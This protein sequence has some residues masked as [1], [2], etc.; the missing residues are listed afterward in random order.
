MGGTSVLSQLLVELGPGLIC[1]TIDD[2]SPVQ[3]RPVGGAKG[4]LTMVVISLIL[5]LVLTLGLNLFVR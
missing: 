3:M 2:M 4:C 5:S 1:A